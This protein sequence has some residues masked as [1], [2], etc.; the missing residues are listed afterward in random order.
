MPHIKQNS[1]LSYFTLVHKW[2]EESPCKDGKAVAAAA[3]RSRAE[4]CGIW[5]FV[6][7][8]WP[9][10]NCVQICVVYALYMDFV[11]Q[12]FNILSNTA[13]KGGNSGASPLLCSTRRMGFSIYL[14]VCDL[15]FRVYCRKNGHWVCLCD[16]V[17]PLC[18]WGGRDGAQVY[19][20]SLVAS[21][22]WR[23]CKGMSPGV[24]NYIGFVVKE[25]WLWQW[26]PYLFF[27]LPRN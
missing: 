25:L 27:V 8:L 3:A 19:H 4:W 24:L 13:A 14:G 12:S 15:G 26:I 7:K 6:C 21:V 23:K 9:L 1:Y 16:E 2:Y 18:Q 10:K 17:V 22:A 20:H 5:E 11:I